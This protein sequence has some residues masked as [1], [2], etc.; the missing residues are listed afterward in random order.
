MPR[1]FKQKSS[2][3][4]IIESLR[5]QLRMEYGDNPIKNDPLSDTEYGDNPNV[6]DE[7]SKLND[8][9]IAWMAHE[10]D[11]I[12][13]DELDYLDKRVSG[14]S[15]DVNPTVLGDHK[16]WD[17]N[18]T[19]FLAR[20][21][22]PNPN[23]VAPLHG[24][25]E[26]RSRSLAEIDASRY[27][28]NETK[29]LLPEPG[30]TGRTPNPP[31]KAPNITKLWDK[32][33]TD[34]LSSGSS[35][36]LANNVR[37]SMNTL[38]ERRV[39]FDKNNPSSSGQNALNDEITNFSNILGQEKKPSALK[40]GV[41]F[42]NAI[43]G[44]NIGEKGNLDRDELDND[45]YKSTKNNPFS[46]PNDDPRINRDTEERIAAAEKMVKD[47][48]TVDMREVQFD[49]IGDEQKLRLQ[50]IIEGHQMPR[51]YFPTSGYIGPSKLEKE[52]AEGI[53]QFNPN[54]PER[55]KYQ[56]LLEQTLKPALE[57]NVASQAAA[58]F[59]QRMSENP[60]KYHKELM[61][62]VESNYLDMI[63]N[64]ATREY[65]DKVK[66][67]NA[68]YMSPGLLQH[69]H[70]NRDLGRANELA[71]RG[72]MEALAKAGLDIRGLTLNAGLQHANMQAQGANIAGTAAQNDMKNRLQ[73]VTSADT[74]RTNQDLAQQYYLEAK[75]GIGAKQTADATEKE[76][77][78]REHIK[79]RETNARMDNE[80]LIDQFGGFPTL[81]PT[82][83]ANLIQEKPTTGNNKKA[84]GK[85]FGGAG[86]KLMNG[87]AKGGL[88]EDKRL[89][90][91]EG[92][93]VNSM[94]QEAIENALTQRTDPLAELRRLFNVDIR[95]K[96]PWETKK[97][98]AF[99][100]QVSPI[101]AGADA[102][103]EYALQRKQI[104]RLRDAPKKKSIWL[105][106]LDAGMEAAAGPDGGAFGNM[107]SGWKSSLDQDRAKTKDRETKLSK[108]DELE[109]KLEKDIQAKKQA[110]RKLDIDEQVAKAK[111]AKYKSQMAD[112]AKKSAA[113]SKLDHVDLDILGDSSKQL[114]NSKPYIKKLNRL[115]ELTDE[116][117]TGG[118]TSSMPIIGR[119]RIQSWM[120]TGTQ[121]DYDE[122]DKLS[123][124]LVTDA[125]AAFGSRGGARIAAIIE[126]GKPNRDMSRAGLKAIITEMKEAVEEEERL[127][128]HLYTGY[129]NGISP[130]VSL[131]HYESSLGKKKTDKKP[132]EAH[133]PV[134]G[135]KVWGKTEPKSS[136]P[137]SA[138][139][140]ASKE[141]L[142]QIKAGG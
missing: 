95:N 87:K 26:P 59:L 69:G 117:D 108:A 115:N 20:H 90:R 12:N 104:S 46:T 122:F 61:G 24:D 114:K 140:S 72:R 111:M 100:G 32:H 126:K 142:Q 58:P 78:R 43:G 51:T 28:R 35:S 91:A 23:Y 137:K 76:R 16:R 134:V 96:N 71:E 42:N 121:G 84:L 41:H 31:T 37:T 129:E 17:R 106:A 5:K 99:G 103:N 54:S 29:K 70:K 11:L 15:P 139:R 138:I 89:K 97:Y 88:I 27:K 52:A 113:P 116:I 53:E 6:H 64:K 13:R 80:K 127:A 125:T 19:D 8:Y 22:L 4:D 131:N 135:G 21:V 44:K 34:P 110:D 105:E 119:P 68:K 55:Q 120:G 128:H 60:A 83:E 92:G 132:D 109:Y 3:A 40:K 36:S 136:A 107:A 130:K 86:Q 38:S 67:I 57:N 124:S 82:T 2:T 77:M 133:S 102:A 45:L 98:Y 101:Q 141:E 50:K 66:G 118:F 10:K 62:N 39:G 93:P 47:A 73:G 81:K 33:T 7:F 94:T 14:K 65:E 18:T 74:L 63:N 9:E 1:S 112:A 123:N 56:Q 75:S 48:S 85:A 30:I 79:E 25:D 49:K